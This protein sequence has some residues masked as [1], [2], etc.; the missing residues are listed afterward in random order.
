MLLTALLAMSMV[1][2]AQDVTYNFDQAADFAIVFDHENVR[3]LFHGT[4]LASLAGT[5]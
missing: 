4:V 1:L 3:R 5:P 2:V